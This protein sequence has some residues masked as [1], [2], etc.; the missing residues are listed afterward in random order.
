ML[1]ANY[2]IDHALPAASVSC[3]KGWWSA[4]QSC[5][6]VGD[7]D[8]TVTQAKNKCDQLMAKLVSISTMDVFN[9]LNASG[10]LYTNILLQRMTS[11]AQPEGIYYYCIKFYKCCRK[12]CNM[13]IIA[14]PSYY[15][16]MLD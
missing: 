3:P 10:K 8:V 14:M 5:I 12:D 7:Q 15:I 1:T 4:G 13:L 9:A 6:Y 16:R 11:F 2:F